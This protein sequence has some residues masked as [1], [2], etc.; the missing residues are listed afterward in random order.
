MWLPG[1]IRSQAEL[2]ASEVFRHPSSVSNPLMSWARVARPSVIDQ[3]PSGGR[4]FIAR[5]RS[6]DMICTALI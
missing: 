2:N 6:V 5:L 4:A 1:V 3:K